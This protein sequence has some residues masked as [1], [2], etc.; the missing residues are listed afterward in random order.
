MNDPAGYTLDRWKFFMRL[1]GVDQERIDS[2]NSLN[3]L[4]VEDREKVR[5]G[6]RLYE[7]SY[8]AKHLERRQAQVRAAVRRHREKRRNH[9]AEN[10]QLT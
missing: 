7:R 1:A 4:M 3:D 2:F 10:L 9:Q 8:R 6:K 5:E